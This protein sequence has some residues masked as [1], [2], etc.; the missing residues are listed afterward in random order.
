MYPE[1]KSGDQRNSCRQ[2]FIVTL[3][4]LAKVEN[5]PYVHPLMKDK[6]N[7]NPYSGLLFTNKRN[8]MLICTI[9][10]NGTRKM[11]LKYFMVS[12]RSQSQKSI[13]DFIYM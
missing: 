9:N 4:T 6:Q 8:E 10:A 5:T 3:F 11:N 2:M 13:Y 1:L 7:V 12:E